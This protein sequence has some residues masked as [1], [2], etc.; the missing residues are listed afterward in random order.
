[1][2]VRCVNLISRV[3]FKL[4]NKEQGASIIE[5]ALVLP[6]LIILVIGI[7]EFGW[8]L[9]GYITITGA[10]RE[11][12]RVASVG[13][14]HVQAVYDHSSSMSALTVNTPSLTRGEP[15]EKSVVTVTGSLPTLVGFF[16]FL[17]GSYSYTAEATMRQEGIVAALPDEED[18]E[19]ESDP[20]LPTPTPSIHNNGKHLILSNI[21]PNATV[22]LYDGDTLIGTESTNQNQSSV[23]FNNIVDDYPGK[24]LRF[25]QINEE[26]D[27]SED[28]FFDTP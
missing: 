17:G 21:S 8:I 20:T 18:E 19:N 1:M 4:K 22:Y 11:G 27:Y 16:D 3:I 25:K 15:G 7:I 5:F 26:G 23:T 6:I 12:A 9:T 14:N 10:A 2:I 28:G 13:G 24:T